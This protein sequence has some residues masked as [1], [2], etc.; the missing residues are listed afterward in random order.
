MTKIGVIGTGKWGV[1]HVRLYKELDCKLI[2]IADSNPEVKKLADE[3]NI[4][5]FTNYSDLLPLVDAVSI[6]TP[7]DTHYKIIKDCLNAGKNVYAEKPITL[8]HK[9][10]LELIELA[11]KNNLILNVGYLYRFNSVVRELKKHIKDAG[12]LHY[13]NA[14]YIHSTK[15]PRK[16]SGAI[17][18]L[19]IHLIDILNFVL[20]KK[21]I[22]VYAK[23]HNYINKDAEECASLLLD[24][25]SFYA[26]FELSSLHPEKKRDMWIFGSKNKIYVDLFEQI[27]KIYPLE[28]NNGDLKRGPEV[29][30]EIRKNEPLKDSLNNFLHSIKGNIF[31]NFGEEEVFTTKLCELG[32]KSAELG[33]EIDLNDHE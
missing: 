12:D 24:Y 31:Y 22:K 10:A 21:P 25:G 7:T 23:K 13:I 14:R 33:K 32:L 28:I 29:N 26:N 1:N 19:G 6:V 30:V 15:P 2:G 4:Q 8:K 20:D 27:L 9:Q 11:K 18:N 3:Y 5:F 17:F 16:D